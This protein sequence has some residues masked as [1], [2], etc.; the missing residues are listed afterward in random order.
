MF[1]KNLHTL[2]YTL[3]AAVVEALDRLERKWG[4]MFSTVFKTIT[5][6]NGSEFSDCEG[7]ERSAREEGKKRTKAYYCHPYSS[8]ER[9][10]NENTNKLIRRHIPK[11]TNFDDKTDDEVQ[12]IEKWVNE[13]PRKIHGYQSAGELF[14]EEIRKIG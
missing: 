10:S 5:V 14:E 2:F 7:I 13:Y 6:D 11:G 9:G 3:A 4:D 1:W 8:Y 12:N